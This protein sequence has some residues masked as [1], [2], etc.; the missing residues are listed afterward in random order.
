MGRHG[1]R[2]IRD[3]KHGFQF[4]KYS[5]CSNLPSRVE[6]LPRRIWEEFTAVDDVSTGSPR[7]VEDVLECKQNS[8]ALGVRLLLD[9]DL[10][11]DHRHYTITEL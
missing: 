8:V 1:E 10:A 2:S 9:V 5:Q 6:A 7:A 11:I 4:S 3:T